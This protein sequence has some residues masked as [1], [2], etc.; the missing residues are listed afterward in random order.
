[1]ARRNH[2]TTA[3][4]WATIAGVVLTFGAL[5][6]SVVFG[7]EAL[8]R[9][10]DANRVAARSLDASIR[11]LITTVPIEPAAEF[12]PDEPH[13]FER[14]CLR[15]R[16]QLCITPVGSSRP[17]MTWIYSVP[18]Q[19]VGPGV[20][21]ITRAELMH[22]YG[23]TSDSRPAGTLPAGLGTGDEV[24]LSFEFPRQERMGYAGYPV[25]EVDYEDVA[26]QQ[27][28]TTQITFHAFEIEVRSV[29]YV[30]RD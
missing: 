10:D 7:V 25:L 3:V 20:A 8:R 26:G 6:L 1:M 5:G 23:E 27:Q 15:L 29:R 19:N 12:Q 14:S 24:R 16:G 9:A 18:I 13:P 11:P 21:R 30:A 4:S 17:G 28:Q 2:L 22:D